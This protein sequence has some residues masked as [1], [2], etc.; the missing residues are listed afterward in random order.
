ME[1]EKVIHNKAKSLGWRKAIQAVLKDFGLYS[2]YR[3]EVYDI[4]RMNIISSFCRWRRKPGE[5]N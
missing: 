2:K 1:E 5:G 3:R 4:L